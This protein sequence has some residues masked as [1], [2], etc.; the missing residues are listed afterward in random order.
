MQVCS[1]V[2]IMMFVLDHLEL[3]T[4]HKPAAEDQ[5]QQDQRAVN[6]P[7]AIRDYNKN[8]GSMDHHDQQLQP[9][10]VTRKTLKWYEYACVHFLQ[11]AM[12]NAHI[13][14]K[15]AGNSSTFLDFQ[16]DVISAMIFGDQDPDTAEG[17][18]AVRLCG[19]HFIDVIPHTPQKARLQR[20]C[21]VSWKKG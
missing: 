20:R 8:M 18:H 3:T 12:L 9:Y 13:L 7:P 15:K 10:D 21:R 1:I 14:N 6:K 4:C 11:I 2:M 17:D 5:Q 16:K 19:Q